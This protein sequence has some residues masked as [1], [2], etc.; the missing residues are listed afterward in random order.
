MNNYKNI[1]YNG[2]PMGTSQKE[3]GELRRSDDVKGNSEELQHRM[4]ED[5]Y[6][7]IPGLLGRD[8]VKAASISTAKRLASVGYLAEGSSLE[9]CIAAP[10]GDPSPVITTKEHLHFAIDENPEINHMI[11][12]DLL[13][14]TFKLF[15][16]GE[17]IYLKNLSRFLGPKNLSSHLKF[18]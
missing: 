18:F 6:L 8:N 1:T 13:M 16:N 7:F 12:G 14:G 10:D 15:L 17:P 4:K 9:K 3:F 11:F 2:R 5:G